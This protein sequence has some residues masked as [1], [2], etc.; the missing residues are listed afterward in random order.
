MLNTA[1]RQTNL[2][3]FKKRARKIN[4][5]QEA[6]TERS[7]KDRRRN[8]KKEKGKRKKE[9]G[10]GKRKKEKGKRKRKKEKRQKEVFFFQMPVLG[11]IFP[12]IQ[13]A[14]ISVWSS[15]PNPLVSYNTI[16]WNSCFVRLL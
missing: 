13:A 9:K 16:G 1:L 4:L 3:V 7:R 6:G 10:K 8:R 11:L 14:M 15:L 5:S 2:F 12:A